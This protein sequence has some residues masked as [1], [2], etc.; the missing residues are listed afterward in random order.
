MWSTDDSSDEE[1]IPTKAPTGYST[2]NP[3]EEEES[4]ETDEDDEAYEQYLLHKNDKNYHRTIANDDVDTAA[5]PG[6][7]FYSIGDIPNRG[8]V[9]AIQ[10]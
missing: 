4:E 8:S 9:K 6:N 5:T 2:M 1:L 3:R 10:T 7:K